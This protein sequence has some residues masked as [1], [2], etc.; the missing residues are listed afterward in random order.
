MDYP[1]NLL[2]IEDD[3]ADYLLVQR[4][5][6]KNGLDAF[7]H[8]VSDSAGL[9]AALNDRHW[10]A[11][12]SDYNVPGMAFTQTLGQIRSALPDIPLILVSGTVG[13][14]RAIELFKLGMTDFVLKD[15]L[16]RLV[17]AITRAL[18]EAEELRAKRATEDAL[19]QAIAATGLGMFDYYPQSGRL[20]C[21]AELKRNVGLQPD[22]EVNFDIFLSRV[23]PEDR[24]HVEAV[25][26]QAMLGMSNGHFNLEHR[27]LGFKDSQE[28]WVQTRGQVFFDGDGKPVR[29]I[30]TELDLTERKQAEERIRQTALHDPLTGLPNRGWLF[31]S[32]QY[33]FGHARRAGRYC[34]IIFIDLDR[35]KPINDN[36]GHEVGD[37]VLKEV[38]HRLT[39]C[40][41][42][43]DIVIRLGGDE[44]LILVPEIEYDAKAEDVARHMSRCIKRPYLVDGLELTISTS[45]GISIFP[46]D[47]KDLDTLISRADAAMY[48]AKQMGRDN[49]Q[50]YS[51]ELA[52]KSRL[53]SRIE[54]QLKTALNQNTFQLHYQPVIDLQT[55]RL[56]GVEAL[57]RWP[58][59]DI[60]PDQFV[61]VAESTGHIERLGEWVISEAC[62]QHRL[63]RDH[64]LPAIPIAVNVSA[65]QLRHPDF[66]NQVS[67]MIADFAINP[68]ALQVEVTET[69]LIEH[70]DWAIDVLTRLQTLG[71]QIALDDFGTGYSSLNYLSRLPINKIKIDKSFVQRIEQDTASRA[72]TE[73]VI[74]LGRTL[75][76]EVVAEG[77]ESEAVLHYLRGQ[78]CSQA[79]G[80]HICRPIPA[81]AFEVW[82]HKYANQPLARAG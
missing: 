16:A 28:R 55:A 51:E 39:Q 60:G 18:H 11:V 12:L 29:C 6:R 47:G 54:G 57:V 61:P 36:H 56:I 75:K 38:A 65:V 81:D 63:W 19:Q 66:A 50:F 52:A 44:F 8:Q 24:Q 77:I 79:Q 20:E 53:K 72:I 40:I 17:P 42:E 37:K 5:L 7:M 64:G 82:F 2:V 69:A 14:E 23:H 76:L 71:V 9:D 21:N 43:E 27:S 70:L 25:I 80:F 10:H 46:R 41:R 68:L 30:G 78:G 48:Q 35:F 62:R 34:G 3:P 15:N 59:E 31:E 32:A 4:H 13:E 67:Q 33:V 26:H 74:A 73:A 22:A 49:I 45:V 58:H 1:L